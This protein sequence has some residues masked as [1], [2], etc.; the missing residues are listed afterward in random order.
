MVK[1]LKYSSF[2]FISFLSKILNFELVRLLTKLLFSLNLKNLILPSSA[3][4]SKN[5][6]SLSEFS[7][8]IFASAINLVGADVPENATENEPGLFPIPAKVE[9]AALLHLK[10]PT[11][12]SA[13]GKIKYL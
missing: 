4:S 7:D 12:S 9:P 13:A 6:E 1:L 8:N 2:K 10:L 11:K 3:L 5:N